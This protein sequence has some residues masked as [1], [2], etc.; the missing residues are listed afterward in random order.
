MSWSSFQC[1]F[2]IFFQC[3]PLKLSYWVLRFYDFLCFSFLWGYLESRGSQVNPGWLKFF[4]HYFFIYFT[5][6]FFSR[7][8]KKKTNFFI[9]ISCRRWWVSWVNLCWL[10][11]VFFHISFLNFFFQ[12]H[13]LILG[14]WALN[15][16]V[17]FAFHFTGYL[18]L[19]SHV[20]VKLI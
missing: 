19:I 5:S 15:F 10:V 8:F 16:V 2:N 17:F 11:F 20:L 6:N 9:P 13:H 3:Y 7:S 14:C 18:D 1:F 4:F 12:F